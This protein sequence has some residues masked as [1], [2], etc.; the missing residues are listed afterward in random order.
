MLGAQDFCGYYDWTFHHV[1]RHFGEAAVKEL[2]AIAVGT[3]S[4]RH[5]IE[6]GQREGL[7]GL[8]DAWNHTGKDEKCDWTFTLDENNNVLRWDMRECPS[9]GF[10]IRNDLHADEDY[11][12][13]CIGWER[14][15]LGEL[16]MEMVHHE[17]NHCGQCWGE[18]RVKGKPYKT[19][20]L[21]CDIRKD[22]RWNAGHLDRFVDQEKANGPDGTPADSVETIRT[23]VGSRR[24]V[25]NG[26]SMPA[27]VA[28]ICQLQ[29]VDDFLSKPGSRAMVFIGGTESPSALRVL[30]QAIE[31]VPDDEKPLLLFAYRPKDVGIR[32]VEYGLL[33][34]V[35]ILPLLIRWGAYRH[36]PTEPA[37]STT[38]WLDRIAGSLAALKPTVRGHSAQ[39]ASGTYEQPI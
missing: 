17:H 25:T 1:R 22:A 9:K 33:R 34:P 38:E 3:D 15:M 7:K 4:Q 37:R 23:F 11:C 19:M 32:F 6:L 30:S 18:I 14:S 21:D 24:V 31:A 29:T 13:H 2:W 27:G 12:D 28:E 8:F 26:E 16:G 36:S 39:S 10:L 5:Y 20:D 35:P